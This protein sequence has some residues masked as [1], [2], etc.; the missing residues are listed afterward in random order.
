MA[1]WAT[2]CK[3]NTFGDSGLNFQDGTWDAGCKLVEEYCGN[4]ERRVKNGF[5]G[6]LLYEDETADGYFVFFDHT[7]KYLQHMEGHW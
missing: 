4:W 3:E 7:Q 1:F 6:I 2:E 5:D